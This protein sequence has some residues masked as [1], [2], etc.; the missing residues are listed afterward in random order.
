MKTLRRCEQCAN[1]GEWKPMLN[2]EK[3]ASCY[4]DENQKRCQ[5]VIALVTQTH[6]CPRFEWTR[7]RETI[8]GVVI[9][10]GL[11]EPFMQELLPDMECSLASLVAQAARCP[12]EQVFD[13]AVCVLEAAV[14]ARGEETCLD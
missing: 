14:T 6:T 2:G 12:L 11:E 10:E 1:A 9:E 3:L 7:T 4:L 8:V 13:A 5:D